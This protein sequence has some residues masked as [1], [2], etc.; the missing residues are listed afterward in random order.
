MS[1]KLV[2]NSKAILEKQFAGTT[3]GYNALQVDEFLDKIIKDYETVENNCL[4]LDSEVK[5]LEVEIQMLRNKNKELLLEN[6]KY[7]SRLKNVKPT[8]N[9]N[10]DNIELLKRIDKLEKFIHDKG[11][12]IS[13]IK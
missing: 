4:L 6:E 2:L 3:P 9:V 13:E 11:Y 1:L 12:D 8:A 7:A 10:T 5:D